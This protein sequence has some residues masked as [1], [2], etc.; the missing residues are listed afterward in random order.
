M[1]RL[2]RAEQG[3]QGKL[4]CACD[5]SVAIRCHTGSARVKRY[6][7]E[8]T[9]ILMAGS[10]AAC[11]AVGACDIARTGVKLAER[12]LVWPARRFALLSWQAG[13]CTHRRTAVLREPTRTQRTV[14]DASMEGGRDAE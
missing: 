2:S 1:A 6:P 7:D 11:A 4:V 9:G 12:S 8:P 3:Q 5:A 13:P 14:S 10:S